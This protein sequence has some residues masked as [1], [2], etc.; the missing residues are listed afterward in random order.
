MFLNDSSIF[1]DTSN[2]TQEDF[3]KGVYEHRPF[4]TL[5]WF[6]SLGLTVI[7]VLLLYSIVWYE[8]YGS[9]LKRTLINKFVVS[10]CWCG[11]EFELVLQGLTMIRYA[12]K[13]FPTHVCTIRTILLYSSTMNLLLFVDLNLLSRFFFIFFLKNPAALKDDFW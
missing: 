7:N 11:I 12:L 8:H 6:L 5:I 2:L 13:P 3:F 10:V 1:E 9:D 4:K